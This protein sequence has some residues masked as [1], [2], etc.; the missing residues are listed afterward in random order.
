MPV[1]VSGDVTEKEVAASAVFFPLAGAFQGLVTAVAA[2]LLIGVVPPDVAAALALLC[3]ILTNGGFD[4]DGLADTFDAL[5]V[6][7]S[8]DDREG[9]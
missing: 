9:P 3:L 4:L 1:N 7:S 8:G 5:A 2:S 6:K